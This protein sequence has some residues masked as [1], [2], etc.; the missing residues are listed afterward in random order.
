MD[1]DPR[2]RAT[3]VVDVMECDYAAAYRTGHFDVVFAIP[4]CEQLSRA[5][6][7]KARDLASAEDIVLERS[8]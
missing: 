5:R 4:S 7:T 6:T 8:R 1:C 3:L 2:S